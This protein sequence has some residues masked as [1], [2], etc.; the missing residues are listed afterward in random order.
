MKRISILKTFFFLV[1]AVFVQAQVQP[2][3]KVTFIQGD[4]QYSKEGSSVWQPIKQNVIVFSDW[5]IKI[6]DD[7]TELEIKWNSGATDQFTSQKTFKV[8]DIKANLNQTNAMDRLKNQLNT[9]LSSSKSSKIQGVAGVRRT[10]VEIKK[11]DTTLYWQEQDEASFKDGITAYQN[12][13][14][15]KAIN[16]L[17]KYILQNP[18]KKN[19]NTELAIVCLL[20]M[21]KAKNDTAKV[22]HVST[23]L[24]QD[25]PKSEFIN[26]AMN[27][28]K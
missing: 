3:G 20:S 4:A 22:I 26:E 5:V 27:Y 8:R 16:I 18:S 15:T 12:N 24:I 10:E 7:E 17:E 6:A 9:V 11:K 13:D 19:K 28:V 14:T 23:R 21:Y 1:Y 2:V 25:F